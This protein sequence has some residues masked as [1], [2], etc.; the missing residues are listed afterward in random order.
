MSEEMLLLPGITREGLAALLERHGLGG[1]Q[2]VVPLSPSHPAPMLLVNGEI[3]LRFNRNEPELPMLA[4]EAAIYRRLRRATDVPGPHVLA[5]DTRRDLLP[6]DVLCLSYVEGVGGYTIWSRLDQAAREHVSEELGRMC[7]TV[8]GLSWPVY[9]QFLGFGP[10]AVQSGRWTDII[11][12]K[13]VEVYEQAQQVALLAPAVLDELIAVLNDG[14]ALFD[15]PSLPTL[16]HTDL[17][18][19]NVV[20]RQEGSEW[21]VAAILD[22]RRSIV[23]DAAWEFAQLWR[24]PAELYPV[25]DSFMHG[26]KERHPLQDDLRVRQRLYRLLSFCEQAVVCAKQFGVS[27]ERTQFFLAGISRLLKPR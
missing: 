25:S 2:S 6:A 10:S 7:A 17:G 8:H 20:L 23:A 13:I 22:W 19:W 12:H 11:N 4:W 9:G 15:T 3:V 5:L 26:Y 18:L 24:D 14:D 21:H 1:L 27:A 16:A